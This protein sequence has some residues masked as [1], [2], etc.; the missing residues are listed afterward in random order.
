M[1]N[2]DSNPGKDEES[3]E[4]PDSSIDLKVLVLASGRSPFR[5]WYDG[6]RDTDTR[7]RINARLLRV[8]NGNLGDVKPVGGDVYELRLD[9]GPGF[10]VYFSKVGSTVIV[11]LAGGDKSTQQS[12]ISRA[13]TLW[14]ENK[15][16]ADR[17]Q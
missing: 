17:L 11:L 3:T 4:L 15:D 12:D 2:R 9:F 10:R 7:Q 6:I 14:K 13:I 1:R 8:R 5:D 16:D